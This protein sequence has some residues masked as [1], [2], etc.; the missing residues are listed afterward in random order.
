MFKIIKLYTCLI[1]N[2]VSKLTF[3][4]HILLLSIY[5]EVSFSKACTES[6]S[7]AKEQELFRS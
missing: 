3:V 5:R 1:H 6:Y 7:F 2:L 4:Y